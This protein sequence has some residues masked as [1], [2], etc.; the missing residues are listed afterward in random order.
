MTSIMCLKNIIKCYWVTYDS[1]VYTTFVIHHSVF[2]LPDLLFEMHPCGL[3]MCYSKKM[4]EF[5]SVQTI[6]GNM[7]L[8]SKWQIAGAMS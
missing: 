4:G 5:G 7:K 1:K 2:G 6:Q 3:H 8:F